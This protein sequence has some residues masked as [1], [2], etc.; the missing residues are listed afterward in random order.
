MKDSHDWATVA[1]WSRICAD[2][3][4][5]ESKQ[6]ALAGLPAHAKA[7]FRQHKMYREGERTARKKLKEQ[8]ARTT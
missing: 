6:Y 2:E 3:A 8:K 1:E 7:Q 5:H 4:L